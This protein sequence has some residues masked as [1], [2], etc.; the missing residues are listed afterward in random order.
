MMQ[1][2][3]MRH[4]G[5]TLAALVAAGAPL[6]AQESKA[7]KPSEPMPLSDSQLDELLKMWE[8]RMS[9]VDRFATKC[10]RVDIDGLRGK[11]QQFEGVAWFLKPNMAKLDMTNVEKPEDRELYISNGDH[12]Y[13]YQFRNKVIRVHELPKGGGVSDDT[14]FSLLSGMKANDARRRYQLSAKTRPNET[15]YHVY[16]TVLPKKDS[17]KQEFT[18]A[19]LTFF[20]P[21]VGNLDPKLKPFAMLPRRLWFKQPNGNEVTWTFE[22]PNVEA[23][24]EKAHFVQPAFPKDWRVEQAAPE[25]AAD[26]KRPQSIYTLPNDNVP[27]TKVRQ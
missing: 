21:H 5:L 14:F 10:S 12:L 1:E 18:Q 24:L 22:L 19:Q 15:D 13:E 2:R 16:V 4:L 25:G 9:K 26:P 7:P 27:P 17:D 23:K 20:A 8:Q 3:D 6:F 11:K